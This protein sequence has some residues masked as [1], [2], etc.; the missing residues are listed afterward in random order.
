MLEKSL[1]R[2]GALVF[3][4]VAAIEWKKSLRFKPDTYP[5]PKMTEADVW[6]EYDKNPNFHVID[7]NFTILKVP[8]MQDH[9]IT[10]AIKSAPGKLIYNFKNNSSQKYFQE[11]LTNGQEQGIS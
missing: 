1:V 6:T 11:I 7:R 2:Y 4:L 8:Q 5:Y 3:I 10:I 9:K